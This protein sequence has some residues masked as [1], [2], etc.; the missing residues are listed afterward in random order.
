MPFSTRVTKAQRNALDYDLHGRAISM[1]SR[2]HQ[3]RPGY[4]FPEKYVK[5]TKVAFRA[6]QIVNTAL[7]PVQEEAKARPTP[8]FQVRPTT[9]RGA[10]GKITHARLDQESV[11]KFYE[12][13]CAFLHNGDRDRATL[14]FI[15]VRELAG[16]D[17]CTTGCAW[18]NDGQCP[19][20]RKLI[21]KEKR[22]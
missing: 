19:A 4:N 13:G 2:Q 11:G 1:A 22:A 14:S 18:F 3:G 21:A 7:I 20:Y 5:P 10:R 8:K 9:K 12:A 15:A 6:Q 16:G 17:V